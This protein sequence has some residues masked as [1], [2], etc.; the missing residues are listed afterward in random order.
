MGA[1]AVNLVLIFSRII[2]IRGV[3]FCLFDYDD[4][5]DVVRLRL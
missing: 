3:C 1:L 5:V 4:D 2:F